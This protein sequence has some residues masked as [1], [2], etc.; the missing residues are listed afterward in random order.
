M[1]RIEGRERFD[2]GKSAG[3]LNRT[4][5]AVVYGDMKGLDPVMVIRPSAAGGLRKLVVS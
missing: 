1:L 5:R 4:G 3:I 2:G